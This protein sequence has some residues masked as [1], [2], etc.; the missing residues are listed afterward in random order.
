[1]VNMNKELLKLIDEKKIKYRFKLVVKLITNKY[2]KI[3][4]F[5]YLF[6]F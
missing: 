2:Y 3:Y 1:M 5:I 6:Y 4:F